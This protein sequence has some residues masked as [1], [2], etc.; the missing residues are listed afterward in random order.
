[1]QIYTCSIFT[2]LVLLFDEQKSLI[3]LEF[4]LPIFP[5]V[6][7]FSCPVLFAG[8]ETLLNQLWLLMGN[9]NK[10]EALKMF[11]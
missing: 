7:V 6:I 8:D 3:F 5:F 1:M 2:V 4:P 11:D 9:W 10:R